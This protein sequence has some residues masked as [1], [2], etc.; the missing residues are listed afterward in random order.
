MTVGK[1]SGSGITAH[2]V[3]DASGALV[4]TGGLTPTSAKRNAP[5]QT[6]ASAAKDNAPRSASGTGWQVTLATVQLDAASISLTDRGIRSTAVL[7]FS[8]IKFSAS[9]LSNQPGKQ[10]T[11]N[12]SVRPGKRGAVRLN[13]KGTLTPLALSFQGKA[14]KADIAFLSPYLGEHVEL[15][16]SEASLNADIRGELKS[17]RGGELD[18]NVGGDAGLQGVSLT[19]G[20][21]EFGGWG[22]LHAEKFQYHSVPGSAGALSIGTLH[23]NGPRISVTLGKDGTNSIQHVLRRSPAQTVP[24]V[25]A[26]PKA[27]PPAHEPPA[28]PVGGFS[29]LSIGGFRVTGGEIRLRDEGLQPPHSLKADGIRMNMKQLSSNPASRGEFE[30]GFRLHGAPITFSGELNPLITLPAGKFKVDIKTFDLAA[31][32]RYAAKFTGYPIRKGELSAEIN[33]AL[34]GLKLDARNVLVIRKLDLGDKD[35]YSDAP[36]MPVKM[37]VSLLS[38]LNGD[39]S[40]SLPISGRLD[41]PQFRLGG[42]MGKVIAN[43]MLKTVTSPISLLGGVFNLF[44]GAGGADLEHISFAPGEDRLDRRALDSLRALAQALAKRPSI[45]LELIGVADMLEKAD[46]VTAEV[47][48][49]MREMKYNSLPKAE[50]AMTTPDKMHVGPDVDAEEY[51]AL[52]SKIYA[53]GRFAKPEGGGADLSRSTREMMYQLRR[54]ASIPDDRVGELA[55]ARAKAVHDELVRID[56]S[57][58]GRITINP[59]KITPGDGAERKVDACVLTKMK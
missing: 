20:R 4:V 28:R 14:D 42:V 41:D 18:V 44:T 34:D 31:L 6:A 51:A 23:L 53:A 26:P 47:L 39:I 27:A 21:K 3:L 10:W 30:G 29:F 5:L 32:S 35:R 48:K 37:A 22:R 8:E 17:G 56:A 9:D 40:L 15:S 2:P 1:I 11:A 36:D 52:L 57:L 58:D 50:R 55:D 45:K 54:S 7:P 12:V 24:A 25:P 38:D 33:V 16:L 46:I 19:E 59:S 13:A 43:I 49:K